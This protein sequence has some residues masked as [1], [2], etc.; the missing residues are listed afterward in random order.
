MTRNALILAVLLAPIA[1]AGVAVADLRPAGDFESIA[2]ESERSA[3]LFTEAGK[4]LTHPRCVN[5]HPSGNSPLQGEDGRIHEP[6]VRRGRGGIGVTGMKCKTCHTSANYDPG[7]VP[8]AA[9][10]LLAP[11]RMAWEGMTV[12]E[13]CEQ[14]KDP[15]RNGGRT[16]DELIEHMAEDEL[17][18][19]GWSPGADR[20]P[21][22]GTQ[23][24]FGELIEAW[25]EAGA[26]CPE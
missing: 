1:L 17:V 14:V 22:P 8:G 5:C 10:W 13:I 6:P 20:E 16:L 18:A 9:H 23:Q 19:W 4:V 15:K 21:V 25:I 24:A 2:D 7:R 12:G 3:A 26:A 11:K